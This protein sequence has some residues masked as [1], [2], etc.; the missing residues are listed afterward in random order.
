MKLLTYPVRLHL[1]ILVGLFVGSFDVA[2]VGLCSTIPCSQ[3]Q[4]VDRANRDP[5]HDITPIVPLP[6]ISGSEAP[7]LME[8]V[9]HDVVDSASTLL[10]VSVSMTEPSVPDPVPVATVSYQG[11]PTYGYHGAGLAFT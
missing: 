7:I 1:C 3:S 5:D 8:S 2:T 6:T 11:P 10:P 4:S 9:A